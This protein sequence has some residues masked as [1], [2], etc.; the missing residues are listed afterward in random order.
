M[1]ATINI[2]TA[3]IHLLSIP[4][5]TRVYVPIKTNK[6]KIAHAIGTIDTFDSFLSLIDTLGEIVVNVPVTF[7]EQNRI[8]KT[9]LMLS[10]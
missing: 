1:V 5:D 7:T 2:E 3:A 4:P 8:A 10:I 6:D 9:R